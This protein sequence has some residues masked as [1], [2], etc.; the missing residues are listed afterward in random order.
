MW[1]RRLACS[2]FPGNA[3]ILPAFIFNVVQASRLFFSPGTLASCRHPSLMW[4][5]RPACSS[6]LG[7]LASCRHSSLMW[8][9]RLACSF[10]RERRSPDRLYVCVCK[11]NSI[12]QS[13]VSSKLCSF[14]KFVLNMI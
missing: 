3:G 5:R 11:S 2:S 4:C 12:R 1:C 9:R 8:C 7:T 14:I 6:S 10:P 13:Y